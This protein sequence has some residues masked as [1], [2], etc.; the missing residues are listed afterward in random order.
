MEKVDKRIG[1]K[2]TLG[3]DGGRPFKYAT[4][5]QLEERCNAY[6]EYIQGE[7]HEEEQIIGKKVNKI[8][9]WDRFPEPA[10]VTGLCL[11]LGFAERHSLI[12]YCNSDVYGNVMK[13]AKL[14]VE[15]GY[16]TALHSDK[17][18]GPIFALKNMGWKDTVEQTQNIT[19]SV[20]MTKEEEQKIAKD[21]ED[22]L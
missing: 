18:T 13:R 22:E 9:V 14:K 2:Y 3:N 20:T 5:E 12:S 1:N 11:F 4:A 19:A 6:F 21:L 7:W 16:E 15:Y 10:T 8:K 17:P